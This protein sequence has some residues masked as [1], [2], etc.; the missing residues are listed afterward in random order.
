MMPTN[1]IDYCSDGGFIHPVTFC[2][3]D[4]LTLRV[5]VRGLNPLMRNATNYTLNQS[6]GPRTDLSIQ[7]DRQAVESGNAETDTI[8]RYGSVGGSG[9]GSTVCDDATIGDDECD[10]HYV[11]YDNVDLCNNDLCDNTY[12]DNH[13]LM[14]IACHET[15]HSVGLTHGSDADPDQG[16]EAAVMGCMQTPP[17]LHIYNPDF[18]ATADPS[19]GQHNRREINSTYPT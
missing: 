14:N 8:Y 12:E 11:T 16:N 10:S 9:L 7:R 13:I 5:Y 2:R 4:N 17:V 19:L 6:Y 1:E 18:G 15:G 3:T